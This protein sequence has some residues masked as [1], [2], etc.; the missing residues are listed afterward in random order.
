M[1]LLFAA[2]PNPFDVRA[3]LLAG[4]AKHPVIVH[5][6]IALFIASAI[7]EILS[8]WRKQPVFEAAAYF[9]LVGAAITL[10]VASA[11]DLGA[12]RWQHECAKLKGTLQM[13]L[14]RERNN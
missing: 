10:P 7:F 6:P 3:A 4:H 14:V 8:M 9:K 13:Y 2:S 12:R 5:F 1:K 11:T